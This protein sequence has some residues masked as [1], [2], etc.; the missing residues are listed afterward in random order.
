MQV[1]EPYPTVLRMNEQELRAL[2]RECRRALVPRTLSYWFYSSLPV[3]AVV[4]V[5]ALIGTI[6]FALLAP[7][8]DWAQTHSAIGIVAAG[9]VFGFVSWL[10]G[11]HPKINAWME[12]SVPSADRSAEN[13]S[14]VHRTLEAVELELARRF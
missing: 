11:T 10:V 1:G 6:S 2:R 9:I 8:H 4:S 7:I 5:L 3:L 12:R 14:L 13:L